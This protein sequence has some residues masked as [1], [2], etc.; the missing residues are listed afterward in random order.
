MIVV[1]GAFTSGVTAVLDVLAVAALQA[2]DVSAS[3]RA[4]R[5]TILADEDRVQLGG[6]VTLAVDGPMSGAAEHDVVVMSALG[7]LN[8]DQLAAALPR[9]TVR[10]AVETLGDLD[11]PRLAAACTGTFALGDAGVLDGGRATTSW[12]LAP[13][14]QSRYPGVEL[15]DDAMVVDDERA[16][17]A[18][19]A[20][21]HVDLA[22]A[23]V[24]GASP[25]L[26]DR[27]AK[28][29][30]LDQRPSQSTYAAIGHLGH[31]DALVRSF[32]RWVRAHL[33]E[34]VDLAVVAASLGVTR[35]TLERRT[36]DALGR[37]PLEVVQR[38]RVEHAQHLLATTDRTLASIAGDVGYASA[39][40]L[41]RLLTSAGH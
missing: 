21:A 15:D 41:R 2:P 22:L 19:A 4:P 20:F 26:A 12:W 34:D 33:A 27:V 32:E 31:S 40:S 28:A 11:G 13:V 6:G 39:S 29:L 16:L 23:I 9:P 10:H 1:D 14:F 37:T 30:V 3:L 24:A 18:G 36:K 8:A 25:I 35:R 5:L 38:L 17:T 7:A